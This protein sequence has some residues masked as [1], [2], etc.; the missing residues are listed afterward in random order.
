MLILI[1]PASGNGGPGLACWPGA[2]R[3]RLVMDEAS[4]GGRRRATAGGG[5]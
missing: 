2:K 4:A 3:L 1:K 5:I